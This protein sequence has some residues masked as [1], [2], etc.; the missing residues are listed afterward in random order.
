MRGGG[1]AVSLGV[2]VHLNLV[3]RHPAFSVHGFF[4]A[5][6]STFHFTEMS[7]LSVVYP[8]A[9]RCQLLPRLFTKEDEGRGRL[10]GPVQV[11]VLLLLLLTL[12]LGFLIP[13]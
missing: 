3:G 10:L 11:R 8:G 7:V 4:S 5:P 6:L 12:F 2:L 13:I 9:L 1:G